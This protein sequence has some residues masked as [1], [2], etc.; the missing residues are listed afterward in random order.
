[1]TTG[2][3]SV[4]VR[5]VRPWLEHDPREG[6]SAEQFFFDGSNLH[7]VQ[8]A[9]EKAKDCANGGRV[10]VWRKPDVP[11]PWQGCTDTA[12]KKR[13]VATMKVAA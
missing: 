2:Y 9:W 13:I 7:S 3:F 10:A 1:M 11:G 12:P 6:L 5:P 8:A 4:P